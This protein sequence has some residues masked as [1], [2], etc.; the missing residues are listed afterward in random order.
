MYFSAIITAALAGVA[1][2]KPIKQIKRQT[3]QDTYDFIIAGGKLYTAWHNG[4]TNLKQV[5]QRASLSQTV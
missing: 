3:I 1:C 5:A 2:A 4:W